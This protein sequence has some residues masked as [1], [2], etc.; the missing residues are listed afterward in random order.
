MEKLTIFSYYFSNFS[1]KQTLYL[2]DED[3]CDKTFIELQKAFNKIQNEDL[4][5]KVFK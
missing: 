2:M 4:E 5:L 1:F 3:N